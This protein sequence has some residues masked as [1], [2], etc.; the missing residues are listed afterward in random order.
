MLARFSTLKRSDRLRVVGWLV[1][2]VGLAGAA[3]RYWLQ[4]RSADPVLD[5]L[6]ALGYSRSLQHGMGVMMGQFGL[7]LTDWQQ[8][9]T[10]PIGQALMTAAC[11]ALVA[12]YFFRVAWVL[13]A[14]SV[15]GERIDQDH[16]RSSY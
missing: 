14:E 9:L 7:V 4:M 15:D 3:G 16:D 6:T 2:G 11:A 1:L 8:I 13:D 12:G 10:S 5:D